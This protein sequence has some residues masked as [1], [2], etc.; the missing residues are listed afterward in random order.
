MGQLWVQILFY[1]SGFNRLS[2]AVAGLI[3]AIIIRHRVP[4]TKQLKHMPKY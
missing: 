4:F 1:D 2:T 3:S